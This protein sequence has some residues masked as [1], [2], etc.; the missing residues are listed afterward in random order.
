[1]DFLIVGFMPLWLFGMR[2]VD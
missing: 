2:R 1:M